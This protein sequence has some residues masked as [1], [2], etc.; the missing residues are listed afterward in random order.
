MARRAASREEFPKSDFDAEKLPL[1]PRG[2]VV[3]VVDLL[4][5]L[6]IGVLVTELPKAAFEEGVPTL[7]AGAVVGRTTLEPI[8]SV[9]IIVKEDGFVDN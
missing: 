1:V 5:A 4:L 9:S 2:V 8:F 6:I 7:P 3:A